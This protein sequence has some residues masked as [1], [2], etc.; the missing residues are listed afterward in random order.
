MPG[1]NHLI[2]S[3]SDRLIISSNS[4]TSHLDPAR[5]PRSPILDA[6]PYPQWTAIDSCFASQGLAR[7]H[8]IWPHYHDYDELWLVTAGYGEG[9]RDG[10]SYPITPNTAVYNPM[11]VV[12]RSQMRTASNWVTFTTPHEGRKRPWM[13][14][15]EEDGPPTPTVPGFVV[16]GDENLGSFP[17]RGPRCPLSE[18]R[19]VKFAGGEGIEEGRI[20][21]NEHWIVVEGAIRLAV[22]KDEFLMTT[23]DAASLRAGTVRRIRAQGIAGA[24]L[25]RE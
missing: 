19:L 3:K 17:D 18:L 11:G 1:V 23:G 13:I 2:V 8:G 5:Y 6:E 22:G 12:H 4:N 16:A 15:V 20:A 25:A 10:R 14:L 9:W 7:W 24:A 21:R